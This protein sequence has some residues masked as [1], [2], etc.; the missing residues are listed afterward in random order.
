M[1]EV[2]RIMLIILLGALFYFAVLFGIGWLL[3]HFLWAG[4]LGLSHGVSI[5]LS[6]TFV[7]LASLLLGYRLQKMLND[8]PF[9]IH[10]SIL[11]F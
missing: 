1:K 11:I 8:L 3:Y 10:C 7:A 2:L 6:I 5:G 4:L 9:T